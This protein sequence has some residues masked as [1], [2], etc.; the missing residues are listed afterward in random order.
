MSRRAMWWNL[1]TGAVWMLLHED[2]ISS[3]EGPDASRGGGEGTTLG[4]VHKRR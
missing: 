2:E 1:P 3:L 4:G